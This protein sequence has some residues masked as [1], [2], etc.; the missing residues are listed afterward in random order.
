MASF[1]FE[2]SSTHVP[3][4]VLVLNEVY[5]AD[6]HIDRDV[7]SDSADLD[8]FETRDR[9]QTVQLP[10]NKHRDPEDSEAQ[11]QGEPQDDD[12]DD[13]EQ[14]LQEAKGNI[15][16]L[17]AEEEDDLDITD[18]NALFNKCECERQQHRL[19]EKYYSWRQFYFFTLPISVMTMAAGIMAFLS[20][21]QRIRKDDQIILATTVGCLS[22][23]QI[24][25]QTLAGKLKFD[26]KAEMHLGASVDLKR[27]AD[28]LDFQK[29]EEAQRMEQEREVSIARRKKEIEEKA[30]RLRFAKHGLK[31]PPLTHPGYSTPAELKKRNLSTSQTPKSNDA[32]LEAGVEKDSVGGKDINYYRAQYAQCMSG[33][34]SIVP[35]IISQAF[36]VMDTYLALKLTKSSRKT[37]EK[38]MGKAGYGIMYAAVCNDIYIEVTNSPG[39]P[40]HVTK[41]ETVVARAIKKLEVAYN[42]NVDFFARGEPPARSRRCCGL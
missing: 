28:D 25:W 40:F 31:H 12:V 34:K 4:Q 36:A 26:T 13:L 10:A 33:C 7:D 38:D 23:I 27:L 5:N 1:E 37:L 32:A 17:E 6:I 39:W 19:A 14:A 2:D 29:V 20:T 21:S 42:P 24:F 18:F 35:L 8:Q 11:L 15:A 30:E 3:A 16:K 41:P 22:L 9:K